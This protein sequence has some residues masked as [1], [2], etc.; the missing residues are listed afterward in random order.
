MASRSSSLLALL[1]ACACAPAPAPIGPDH[2][3]SPEAPTGPGPG[4]TVLSGQESPAEAPAEA[5]TEAPTDL[6]AVEKAAF[7]RAR[8]VLETHCSRCHNQDGGAAAK[9]K[10]KAL[11]HFSLDGYPPGGHHAHEVTAEVRRVLG[12]GGP[13]V[14]KATMPMDR[15]GAV[16]GEELAAI[17]AWADAYD[18]AEQA[19]LHRSADKPAAGPHHHHKH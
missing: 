19:G 8:P 15:P 5:P 16:K 2:P 7:E 14:V 11:P 1:V 17:L 4:D 13:G 12:V 6:L 10:K 3:A 18:A 9:M